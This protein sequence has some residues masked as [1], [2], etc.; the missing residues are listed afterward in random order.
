MRKHQEAL[1]KH[2]YYRGAIDGVYTAQTKAALVACVE[3]GCRV[4]K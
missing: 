3:A 2:G 1:A 4:L